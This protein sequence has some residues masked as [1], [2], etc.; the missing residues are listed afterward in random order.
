MKPTSYWNFTFGFDFDHVS[1][2]A[3]DFDAAYQ[4]SSKLDHIWLS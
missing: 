1:L 3:C 2:A 4:I